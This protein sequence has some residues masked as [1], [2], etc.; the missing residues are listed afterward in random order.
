ML[1]EHRIM[2]AR[3]TS[4]AKFIR[5]NLIESC[6]SRPYG[7]SRATSSWLNI[8]TAESILAPGSKSMLEQAQKVARATSSKLWMLLCWRLYSSIKKCCSSKP[9]M[10]LEQSR[11][12][13]VF[14][15]WKE[16]ARS[17][18]YSCSSISTLQAFRTEPKKVC[19]SKAGSMLEQQRV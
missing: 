7:F 19:S 18:F 9:K 3:A 6:S 12:A 17:W 8:S 1:L 11:A 10:L 16:L 13:G 5:S 4:W 14:S 15:V 2:F